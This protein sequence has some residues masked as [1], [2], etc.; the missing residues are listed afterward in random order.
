MREL[1]DASEVYVRLQN[2]DGTL[3]PGWFGNRGAGALHSVPASENSAIEEQVFA[4][5]APATV[6]DCSRLAVA[7]PLWRKHGHAFVCPVFFQNK[8]LGV[9]TAIRLETSTYF[10]AGQLSLIRVVADFL[11]IART[12]AGLQEERQ[13]EQRVLRGLEIAAEIQQSLLPKSFPISP[14]ARI[15]GI[16]QAA[17]EVGGDYFDAV[18]IGDKGVLLAIADVMGKGMPAALL[19]TVLRTAIRARSDLAENPGR[20]LSEVNRQI[21]S[22][23]AK[24]DMFVTAQVAFFSYE[25]K[26]LTFANAGHCPILKLPRGEKR[27]V[28]LEASGI[29]L[30]VI[31]DVFYESTRHRVAPGD[32]FVFLTDG[33]Y[34]VE[35]ATGEMLGLDRLTA[36]ILEMHSSAPEEFCGELL[37]SVRSYSGNAQASDDRTILFLECLS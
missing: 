3:E 10:T 1:L 14:N 7:D 31:D 27:A 18:Q 25:T 5:C 11:G 37:D 8:A 2:A 12:T 33:L 35:S 4:R 30:G 36:Q 22:D 28:R 23:L 6:E 34:E 17:H 32:R 26:Q 24:L 9:L 15:F 21:S 19:A 16:S 13:T 29:P 20:L